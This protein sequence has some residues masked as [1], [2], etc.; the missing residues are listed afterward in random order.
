MGYTRS[1]ASIERVMPYLRQIARARPTGEDLIWRTD[2]PIKLAHSL[3]Q[4]LHACR[5][6]EHYR[7]YARMRPFLQFITRAPDTVIGQW[8][9]HEVMQLAF[10]DGGEIVQEIKVDYEV[11]MLDIMAEIMTQ[12]KTLEQAYFPSLSDEA[13]SDL[14]LLFNWTEEQGWAIINHEEVGI[15]LTKRLIDAE[16]KWRPTERSVE[17]D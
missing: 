11:T 16:L 1:E 14:P 5:Y 10:E 3:R 9:D 4:A 8:F 6:Y 17:D 13:R 15:T 12:P 2:N 7:A